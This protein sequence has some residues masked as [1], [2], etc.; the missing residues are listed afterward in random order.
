[1][2]RVFGA[3]VGL[4]FVLVGGLATAQAPSVVAPS[5][6]APSAGSP[7]K[8]VWIGVYVNQIEAVSLKDS[9][10]SIDFH[11]WFRWKDDELKPLETFDLTNGKIDNKEDVY[12]S[13]LPDGNH[14]AVCRVLATIDKLWD[15]TSFPLDDHDFTIEIEDSAQEEFKLVYRADADNCG[16]NPD[17]KVAGWA[18]THGGAIVDTHRYSTNYGD[19]SLPT[20]HGSTYSRFVYNLDLTRPG[21]GMAGKLFTGLFIAVLIGCMSL[22]IN[23]SKL[24]ARFALSVGSLFAAVAS[25]YISASALPDT[26]YLTLADK[27]HMLSFVFIFFTLVESSLANKIFESGQTATAVRFDRIC[28][29][30]AILIY[31][32]TV[33]W[34]MF[35]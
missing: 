12:Q 4:L 8:E 24:D 14:Y 3:V 2:S 31:A 1:M 35:G 5:S 33:A 34:L 10:V 7:P 19:T 13:M 20:G 28:C 21:L 30:A 29:V 32:G 11:V 9:K 15:V 23:P 26:N 25:E 6:A 16:L 18:L 17:A 22:L 27:L